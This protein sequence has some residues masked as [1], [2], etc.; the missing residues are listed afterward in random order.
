[1]NSCLSSCTRT[2]NPK[3]FDITELAIAYSLCDLPLP[4]LELFLAF[5][6]RKSFNELFTVTD[7]AR[8]CAFLYSEYIKQGKDFNAFIDRLPK[9]SRENEAALA[10]FCDKIYIF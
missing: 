6:I 9:A 7:V 2:H 4:R 3:S 8:N 5:A 10:K 1:M